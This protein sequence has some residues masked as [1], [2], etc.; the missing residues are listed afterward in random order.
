M[1][2]IITVPDPRLRTKS[3]AIAFDKKTAQLIKELRETLVTKEGTKGVG[4]SAVQI[5]VLQRV[6]VAFSNKSKKMLVFVNPEIIWYSKRETK[7]TPES[8]NKY[9]GCLS[10]PGI[11]GI[12]KRSYTIKVKY[13]TETGRAL[14]RKFSGLTAT[15]IQHEYDHLNG[16][17]FVDRALEQKN[18][19]YQLETDEQGK[20]VLEKI[21]NL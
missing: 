10:V 1:A 3:K 13:Q 4:L 6:F 16:I 15:I 14:V 8:R 19:L 18:E 2:K 17:L 7:G 9:E 12:V 11:W 5:G 21:K 20:E